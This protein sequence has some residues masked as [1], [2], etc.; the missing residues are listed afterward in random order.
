MEIK[1]ELFGEKKFN[2]LIIF[3]K[4]SY[5]IAL[6]INSILH[7]QC[8]LVVCSG[9]LVKKT[10]VCEVFVNPV[11]GLFHELIKRPKGKW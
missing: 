3:E 8:T 2:C 11:K 4:K 1:N 9:R 10:A 5:Q 6:L 7:T